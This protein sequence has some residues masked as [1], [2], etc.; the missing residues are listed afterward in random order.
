MLWSYAVH[1]SPLHYLIDLPNNNNLECKLKKPYLTLVFILC[2]NV[3]C[4]LFQIS[5]LNLHTKH[6][7]KMQRQESAYYSCIKPQTWKKSEFVI[8]LFKNKKV[9]KY[10]FSMHDRKQVYNTENLLGLFC[11]ACKEILH[12]TFKIKCFQTRQVLT[13]KKN[14]C[15]SG[16]LIR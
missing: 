10:V 5:I 1:F 4:Y 12:V 13:A 2:K 15:S 14:S 9:D 11:R 16:C 8:K 7:C 3:P 6:C